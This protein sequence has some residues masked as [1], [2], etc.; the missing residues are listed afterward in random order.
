MDTLIIS[1]AVLVVLLLVFTILKSKSN[2]VDQKPSESKPENLEKPKPSTSSKSHPSKPSKSSKPAKHHHKEQLD[3]YK[4][5]QSGIVD[6]DIKEHYFAVCCEDS[7][8]RVYKTKSILDTKSKYVQGHIEKNQPTAIALSASGDQVFV[9]GSQ[10]LQIHPFHVVHSGNKFTL[11]PEKPFIKK[12]TLQISSLA[13][14]TKCLV[15]CGEEQDTFIYVWSHTGE[16]LTT[17]E[18]KQLKHKYMVIS[19]DLRFF[20][21]ATWL[22]S[23]RVFN[24]FKAKKTEN[25]DG[26]HLILELGGHK[27]GLSALNFSPDG[28]LAVTCGS[29][30]QVKLWNINV[31]YEYKEHPILLKTINLDSTKQPPVYCA[32]TGTRLVL[33]IENALHI[34]T[35][36][37]LDL[38]KVIEDAHPHSIRKVDIVENT[39]I[40]ASTDPR[41]VLWHLD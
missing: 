34:Y 8:I 38:L 12:H 13:W 18:N 30:Q 37:T 21:I 29:D 20:S 5:F 11:E 36:P 27:Q 33:A 22:G 19:K 7:V 35:V 25:Y 23:A 28:C 40:S 4:G 10:D 15:S 39:I 32:L 41:L 17:F 9:G 31:Q 26:I 24:F 16:L 1:G 14:T 2:T 3:L 6:F